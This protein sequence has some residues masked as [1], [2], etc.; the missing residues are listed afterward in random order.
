[1]VLSRS[2]LNS[3][4]SSVV[5]PRNRRGEGRGRASLPTA[6]MGC[7]HGLAAVHHAHEP[8]CTHLCPDFD[9]EIKI[10]IKIKT[11]GRFMGSVHGRSTVHR[12][13]ERLGAPASLPAC[14]SNSGQNRRQGCRRSQCRFMGSSHGLSPVHS[15]HEPHVLYCGLQVRAPGGFMGSRTG[16]RAT[17][18]GFP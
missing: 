8:R 14:G 2:G 15:A 9:G 11:K 10:K 4:S 6:E 3:I 17:G 18:P 12:A 1:M 5:W 13:H 16:R 7:S